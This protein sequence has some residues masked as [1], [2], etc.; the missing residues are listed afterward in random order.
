MK[1]SSSK[2]SVLALILGLTLAF[3]GSAFKP[4]VV[5]DLHAKIGGVWTDIPENYT[6]GNQY[7]CVLSGQCTA[8]FILEENE[9][10]SEEN[11]VP[12]SIEDGT[13]Q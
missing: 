9:E 11:M 1:N 5:G 3:T 8:R 7:N 2:I 4:A 13:Y 10:P 6:K 12:G